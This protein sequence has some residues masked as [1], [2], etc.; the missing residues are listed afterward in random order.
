MDSDAYSRLDEHLRLRL[1]ALPPEMFEKFFLGFLD[2]G[3]SLR[4]ERG[5]RAV[6]KRVI[7]ATTYAAGSGRAD[8]GVDLTAKMEG[9]EIWA[10]QC[11]RCKKWTVSDTRK[12][13]E[14]ATF[15][16]QHYFL[17]VACNPRKDVYDFIAT[18]PNWSLWNLDVICEKFRTLV[19]KNKQPQLLHFLSPDE[20]ERFA[21]YA[22][23]ILLPANDYFQ[24]LERAGNALHHRHSLVGRTK[25]LEQMVAFAR[26]PKGK[27]VLMLSAKG[28]EGKSRLLRAFADACRDKRGAPEILFLNPHSTKRLA[29]ALFDKDTPRVI[30]VDDAHRLERMSPELLSIVSQ[31]D[32]CK[33]MLAVRPQGVEAVEPLL[34]KHGLSNGKPRLDI[35]PLKKM[36]MRQLAEEVLGQNLAYL[37]KPLVAHTGGNPFLTVL[38]GD[39]LKRGVL[40]WNQRHT[41][42]EFRTEIFCAF[43]KDNLDDLPA[44][45][46]KQ[47]TRFLRLIALLAPVS[48][49]PV[50]Y[51]RAAKCLVAD[52]VDVEE[53]LMRLKAA[54]LLATEN[55]N[56]RV[57]PDLFSDFL[58]FDTAFQPERRL[59]QFVHTVRNEFPD[60][61]PAMLRNL[62]EAAWVA[63]SRGINYDTLMQPLL[64]VE[65]ARFERSSFWE[66]ANML[67]QWTSF[68]VFL[69][70]ESLKL[71]TKAQE[72]ARAP[73]APVDDLSAMLSMELGDDGINSHQYVVSRIPALL[74]SVALYQEKYRERALNFIWQLGCDAPHGKFGLSRSGHNH[75]W[76]VIAEVMEFERHKPPSVTEATL[77]WL[78]QLVQRASVLKELEANRSILRTLTEPCFAHS[79][80]CSE[81]NG[82][83]LSTWQLPV[84]LKNTA[85]LRKL[86]LEIIQWV[87]E[88]G[89]WLAALDAV[90]AVEPAMRQIVPMDA[91]NP[92]QQKRLREKWRPE[93]LKAL[94]VLA[95]AL[96]CHPD[97][98]M[99][100]LTVRQILKRTHA[101]ERDLI[102]K[103]AVAKTLSRVG[104][105]F[106]LQLLTVLGSSH[107]FEFG[108]TTHII[109]G[110]I[111]WPKCK[112]LWRDLAESVCIQFMDTFPEI[113]RAVARLEKCYDEGAKADGNFNFN[114]LFVAMTRLNPVYAEKFVHALIAPAR[115]PNIAKFWPQIIYGLEM[116]GGHAATIKQFIEQA[117]RHP[118]SE[119]RCG[120]IE[121]FRV[122]EPQKT[123]ADMVRPLLE[124]MAPKAGSPEADS[125][126]SMVTFLDESEASWGFSLLGKLPLKSLDSELRNRA[127]EALTPYKAD[128]AKPPLDVVVH[129]L[130]ALVEVDEVTI[131]YHGK[132]LERIAELYPRTV[133]DFVTKRI[134]HYAGMSKAASRKYQPLPRSAGDLPFEAPIKIPGLRKESDFSAICT[135]L[136]DKATSEKQDRATRFWCDLFQDIV[137]D[138]VD[139]WH[140]RLVKTIKNAKSI[141]RLWEL[142]RLIAFNGSLIVFRFPE[143]TKAF[144]KQ[145]AEIDGTEGS[146][147]MRSILYCASGPTV[148]SYSGGELN[149][150]NDYVE[151]EALKAAEK[152]SDDPILGPFYRKMV[153][154]ERYDREESRRRHQISQ[155][156]LD[157]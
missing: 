80:H 102:F 13:I 143:I 149:K 56:L 142:S 3:V 26:S 145:A 16:A 8:D 107:Y 40:E 106:D 35:T 105:D 30:V 25:E 151:A 64:E 76:N 54:G 70:K 43:E 141:K 138:D 122:S 38:A 109:D 20:L 47:G 46:H 21:P 79:V 132:G 140:S 18:Q 14:K 135:T 9:G 33:L 32:A 67:D 114:D 6:E 104:N 90:K 127:L 154:C 69:P 113:E 72:L 98:A 29:P 71:A 17:L 130:N 125:F 82:R 157:E 112:Q 89:T 129:V 116:Q 83:M 86:A 103:K 118:Q 12:A 95:R 60:K 93:R 119:T 91:T 111:D 150:E 131:R 120:V 94:D 10:F 128:A 87:I 51:G 126:L 155:A 45:D 61:A 88:N 134:E 133:Y 1:A 84:D 147:H 137:L 24:M 5:G 124:Q 36:D 28:G 41:N 19:P 77:Q 115:T 146:E 44:Q 121:C 78:R 148:R 63:D 48:T 22:T 2:A 81:V 4:I 74:K 58:I 97:S 153:E 23:D 50:F 136:W 108:E 92:T 100:R 55:E 110:K 52:P 49:D 96:D 34:R 75:P 53:I 152:H 99:L 39:L 139:F 101:Y 57:V 59:P 68:S 117:S 42:E 37:A 73:V 85:P 27:K 123:L 7:E 144:L 11:K 15:P 62:A 31:A 156:A 65:Y 66:R